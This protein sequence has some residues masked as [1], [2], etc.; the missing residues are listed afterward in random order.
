MSKQGLVRDIAKLFLKYQLEDWEFLA[1]LLRRGGPDYADIASALV[2][3]KQRTPGARPKRGTATLRFDA[4][5]DSNRAELLRKIYKDLSPASAGPKQSDIHDLYIRAGGKKKQI[6]GRE[7]A[8]QM[9]LM[10]I[11]KLPD[12]M[13]KSALQSLSEKRR[14]LRDEYNKWFSIIYDDAITKER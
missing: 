1:D 12:D 10:Q 13:F 9:F 7:A 2:E 6:H 11:S 8:L 4:D 14:N 3:I 5:V